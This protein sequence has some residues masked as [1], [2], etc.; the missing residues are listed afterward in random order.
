MVTSPPGLTELT[1]HVIASMLPRTSLEV[2]SR[3][4][5]P[6]L[7]AASARSNLRPPT[8]RPSIL[9]EATDS[10]RSRSCASASELARALPL[11]S[12]R[13]SA[14]SAPVTWAATSPSSENRRP[15]SRVG[16]IYLVR[17]GTMVAPCQP[18]NFTTPMP[19]FQTCQDAL[20]Y[21]SIAY[22]IE[23]LLG[24]FKFTGMDRLLM[25]QPTDHRR[26]ESR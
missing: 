21:S 9:D 2:T 14:V 18:D 8:S 6:S 24:L 25:Y 4:S 16:Q 5:T 22:N 10:A 20:L 11:V 1:A 12:S 15:C 7:C 26:S 3:G 17:A 13:A 23:Y 19:L